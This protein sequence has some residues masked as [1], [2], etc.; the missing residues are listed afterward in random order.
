MVVALYLRVS[1]SALLAFWGE[2]VSRSSRV[3]GQHNYY[4]CCPSV[5]IGVT[6]FPVIFMIL[7]RL[8]YIESYFARISEV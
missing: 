4:C 7:V 1:E 6:R 5:Q 3:L 2:V 8:V